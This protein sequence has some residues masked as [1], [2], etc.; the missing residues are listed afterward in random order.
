M[1]P[2]RSTTKNRELAKLRDVAAQLPA[3]LR[4]ALLVMA[5]HALEAGR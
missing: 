3:R 1:K 4:R 2:K 5:R